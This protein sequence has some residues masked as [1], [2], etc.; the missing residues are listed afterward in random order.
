MFVPYDV[1]G[2]AKLFGKE[3]FLSLLEEL[4]TKADLTALWNENYN[5]SN[6]PCHNLT[7]YFNILGKPERTDYWT[8]RVQKEAYRIGAFGFCGNEDVGQLSA[9][10]VL[11]ALGLAQVCI[12][13]PRYYLNTPLFRY[14][15]I[16]LDPEYH[17]RGISERF[18]IECDRDPLTSPYIERVLLNGKE[19]TRRYLTYE[20]ITN[21]GVLS[22]I[23]KK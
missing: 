9:W 22:L 21:G 7:H 14:S 19:L 16:K 10:Y 12:G 15:E 6:E 2:L 8:R 17:G 11:S 1:E 5:H 3:R 18:V 13:E 23:L 4:F 20:E